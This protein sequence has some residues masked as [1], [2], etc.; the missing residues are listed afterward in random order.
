MTR[1]KLGAA[2]EIIGD[3]LDEGLSVQQVLARRPDLDPSTVRR[4]AGYI[5]RSQ[6][7]L[8]MRDARSASCA[9]AAA[10]RRHH[11]EQ[12]GSAA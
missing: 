9:L 11:P 8:W 4:V 2:E 10:I 6:A 3:L 5:G 7:D 1:V 12:V